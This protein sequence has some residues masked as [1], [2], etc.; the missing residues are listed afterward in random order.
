MA[1]DLALNDFNDADDATAR[2]TYVLS[3]G[4]AAS[5]LTNKDMMP[6]GFEFV[7]NLII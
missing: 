4:R 5:N 7:D 1:Y 3:L 2:I 6:T